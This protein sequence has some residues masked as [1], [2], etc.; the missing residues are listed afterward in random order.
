MLTTQAPKSECFRHNFSFD[1]S[2]PSEVRVSSF[3]PSLAA[4]ARKR[5]PIPR[6]NESSLTRNT[7]IEIKQ[8]RSVLVNEM[9]VAGR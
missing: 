8:G 6:R 7:Q 5:D 3:T 2:E 9:R 1:E 4:P